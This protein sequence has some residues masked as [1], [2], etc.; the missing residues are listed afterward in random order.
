MESQRHAFTIWFIQ[1]NS[2]GGFQ[3]GEKKD[4]IS[5][6]VGGIQPLLK[7]YF[8]DQIQRGIN[9]KIQPA[10]DLLLLILSFGFQIYFPLIW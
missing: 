8:G 5:A 4:R 6:S 9:K 2:Q 7:T 10:L 3:L 1:H